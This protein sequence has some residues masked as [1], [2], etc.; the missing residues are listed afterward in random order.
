LGG[1]WG[2]RVRWCLRSLSGGGTPGEWLG[3]AS[4]RCG[5]AV[6]GGGK[7]RKS[8]GKTIPSPTSAGPRGFH[9]V[10]ALKG[11]GSREFSKPSP[12]ASR[13]LIVKFVLVIW[14]PVACNVRTVTPPSLAGVFGL[15]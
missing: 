15:S 9:T 4:R 3:V 8:G 5:G 12:S 13:W 6:G 14:V 10:S 2:G 7:G 1:R 11:Q